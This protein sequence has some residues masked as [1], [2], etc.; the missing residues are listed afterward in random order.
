MTTKGH[1]QTPETRKKL[2]IAL[3]EY[4]ETHTPTWKGKRRSNPWNKG[5]S[6]NNKTKS[7]ISKAM[8]R[9]WSNHHKNDKK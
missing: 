2:S 1:R 7:K 3:K 4:Y 6:H 5:L 9:Y 8:K